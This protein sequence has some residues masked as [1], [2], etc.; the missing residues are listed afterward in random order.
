MP[1][2]RLTEH[3]KQEGVCYALTDDGLELPVVDITHPAF[4]LRI[5]EEKQQALVE[6]F[7]AEQRRFVR[8]PS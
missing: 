7:L 3:H 1:D 5:T 8:L 6:H 4:E 2:V